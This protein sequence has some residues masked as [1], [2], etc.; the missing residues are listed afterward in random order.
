VKT[1]V[2][3]DGEHKGKPTF[4]AWIEAWTPGDTIAAREMRDKAPYRFGST[5][6]SECSQRGKASI[7]GRSRRR[8]PRL[9]THTIV[10]CVAYDRYAFKRGLEP[11]CDL[12]GVKVE[13]VEHPQGGTKK[14]AA[15]DAMKAAAAAATAML[16][17]VDADE[18]PAV[19]RTAS[20]EADPDQN[21][22]GADL[23][24]DVGCHG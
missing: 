10:K 17:V 19:G 4:D 14:G 3:A 7:I 12:L 5:K 6:A 23:G 1:G 15:N 24:D 8:S 11:E 16:K 13:F 21:K 2:V 18:C 20:R 9:P 22:S